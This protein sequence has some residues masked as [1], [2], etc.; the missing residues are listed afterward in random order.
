MLKDD[1]MLS[2]TDFQLVRDVVY[3]HCGISLSEDKISLVRA[4]VAKQMRTGNYG[5]TR[6]YLDHVLKERSGSLF[7][8][9]IDSI[10]TNLTSFFRE[11]Q[12]FDYLVKQFLPALLEQKRANSNGRLLAWS[13]ACSSGEEPYSLAMTLLDAVERTTPRM[14]CDVR[15][16]ATDISTAM[17][18]Q[19]NVGVY[20]ASRVARVPSAYRERFLTAIDSDTEETPFE[21]SAELRKVVRFRHLNLMDQ[22]PFKGPFDFI[23]CRNV[24]I[25][26]E[27]P[28]QQKLVDRFWNCLTPG[29]L[30]F[31]GHSESLTG[32]VSR[33]THVNPSIYKKSVSC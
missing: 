31:T 33:F 3:K 24:M 29:G 5:S 16:L 18:R 4:R 20:G 1:F 6:E 2:D 13:A 7:S 30:L 14:C 28:T 32:I 26:F 21:V 25:Y 9:F 23:F 10:S 22:W 27:K 11:G 8:G 12:H 17:V 15:L 19:A